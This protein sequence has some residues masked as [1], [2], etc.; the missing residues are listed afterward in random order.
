MELSE[1]STD[2]KAVVV[3]VVVAAAAVVVGAVV[4]VVVAVVL[5]P[6][7]MMWGSCF[8]VTLHPE[9]CRPAFIVFQSVDILNTSILH[10]QPG[11]HLVLLVAVVVAVVLIPHTMMWGSCFLV[12]LHPE[13]CRPAFIVFQSVDI[14]NTSILHLQ[15]GCRCLGLSC[16]VLGCFVLSSLVLSCLVVS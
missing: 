3:V 10:L 11:C 8:L 4:I 9:C 7:A 14:L 2:R 6:H 12:T 13:C 1:P 15:P 5:I 16:L